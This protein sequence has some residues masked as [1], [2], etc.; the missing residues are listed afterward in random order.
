MNSTEPRDAFSNLPPP[1]P[2]YKKIK[3]TGIQFA[4]WK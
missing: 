1:V 2:D 3:I 4:S